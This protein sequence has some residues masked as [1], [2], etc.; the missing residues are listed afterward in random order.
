MMLNKILKSK[1]FPVLCLGLINLLVAYFYIKLPFRAYE[2]FIT[3]QNAV[4]FFEGHGSIL[5]DKV[6]TRLLTMPL[7]LLLGWIVG[8]GNLGKGFV[9]MNIIFY[10]LVIWIFYKLVFEIWKNKNIA[11]ISTILLQSNFWFFS[12]GAAYS[13]DLG[14]HFFFFLANF[15]AVK[16]FFSNSQ[17]YFYYTIFSSSI[18]MFFKEFGAL[19]M[20]T[21]GMLILFSS[22]SWKD[23]FYKISEA[24]ILFLILPGIYH[25]WFYFKFDYTYFDWFII[26]VKI[27]AETKS[28]FSLM[29]KVLG[30][31]YLVGWPIFLFS[32]WKIKKYFKTL[33]YKIVISLLPASLA[34]FAWPMF[35]QRTAFVLVP[36]LA[37]CSGFGLS[38]IKNN[39]IVALI[40]MIYILVGYNTVPLLKIINLPF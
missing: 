1:Y 34:F 17:K 19:G 12:Y 38:K 20:M 10:F 11:L 9:I 35:M 28:R 4:D 6:L 26:P 32:L 16:Y 24:A 21:L 2:D 23:K 14:G 37:I 29:I 30:W 36:W 31:L 8:F 5:A 3:Y 40:L 18:G 7:S 13:A 27:G 33:D 22:F 39:Y 15:F 25:L